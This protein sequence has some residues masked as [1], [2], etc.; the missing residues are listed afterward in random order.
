M[1]LEEQEAGQQPEAEPA[2]QDTV[3]AAAPAGETPPQMAPDL[4]AALA[5]EREKLA[6]LTAELEREREKATDYMNRWQRSQAD[7]ANY[8]RRVEQ[9]REQERKYGPFPLFLELLKMQDNFQRAFETLPVEL[10][11]FSWVQGIAL[12][13]AHLDGLLRLHGVTPFETKPGQMFDPAVHEAV[14]HEETD[15]YPDGAITAEYQRG[16]KLYD[17]VLRPALVRV[18][19]PKSAGTSAQAQQEQA[20]SG[21]PAQAGS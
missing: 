8:K 14:T 11:E 20:G 1:T 6:N 12:T 13:Y 15:T 19:K 9:E 3:E 5:G 17:R 4:A 16:Y 7:L 18:A 2:P 21:E 10:R